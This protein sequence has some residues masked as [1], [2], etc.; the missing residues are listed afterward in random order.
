MRIYQQK[1]SERNSRFGAYLLVL[2]FFVATATLSVPQQVHAASC[3]TVPSC[4]IGSKISN[5]FASVSY[6]IAI[7]AFQTLVQSYLHML[8]DSVTRLANQTSNNYQNLS[9]TMGGLSD[10]ITGQMRAMD[11]GRVRTAALLE[12]V[13]SLTACRTASNAN[14]MENSLY[15]A[16]RLNDYSQSQLVATNYAANAPGG[17]TERGSIQASQATFNDMFNGFCD[18][19]VVSPPTGVSCTLVNDASGSP[20]A[21]RFTQPY[22]AVFGVPNGTISPNAADPDN[23]AARLFARMATEPVPT[24]P[25]RGPALTRNEGQASFVRRQ[26]DIAAMNL[27]RG[28]LDHMVDDRIGTAAAGGE[29]LEY[30]RQRAWSDA[31]GIAKDVIDRAGQPSSANMDDLA[32]MINENNKIYLQIYDNMMRFSAMFAAYQARRVLEHSAGQTSLASRG[33]NN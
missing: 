30:L 25:L 23:R 18:P 6:S 8:Q 28:A 15:S 16:T 11:V 33:V 9:Q 5:K 19:A 3:S 24:D 17:P 31:S 4:K 20:M 2:S 10:N 7:S 22:Q 21:F 13:P 32:P 29:S 12:S 27:A 1:S 14:R 26:S